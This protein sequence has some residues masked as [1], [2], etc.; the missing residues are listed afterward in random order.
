MARPGFLL[1]VI[2]QRIAGQDIDCPYCGLRDTI[3]IGTKRL[4]LQLRR[5]AGC[6]L[7]FRWPKDTAELNRRFYQ[8]RYREGV[9]TDLPD[10]VSLENMKA[11]TLSC[12]EK[13]LGDKIG[14]LRMLR[15]QGR[16]L[17]FGCS[18][19]YGTAQLEAAGYDTVGFE[20]SGP[21]AKFA[22]TSM[23]L[24][25]IST[26]AE[27]DKLGGS[28]DAVFASHVLE[29]VPAPSAVFERIASL[30]KPGGLLLAFVPN[31]SGDEAL[32]LGVGWGP[33]CS[34]KHPLALDAEFLE[35]ALPK[36]GLRAVAFS[37]PYC[38]EEVI[39]CWDHPSTRRNLQ[40]AELMVVARKATA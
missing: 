1:R 11:S 19:G 34:E 40:G 14:F 25:I 29:H 13:D 15:P 3:L 28:F 35:K 38:P 30:L 5:C 18:W 6:S 24:T 20:I 22:R 2:G 9:T 7:M 39:A 33:M 37:D 26:D 23:G 12:K 16:V 31:C 21:R 32:Q 17:D 10:E 36:H 4:L 8:R 27:L